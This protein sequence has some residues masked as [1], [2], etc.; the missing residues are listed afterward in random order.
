MLD[1]LDNVPN[2]R[3]NVDRTLES[4][5]FVPGTPRSTP[6]ADDAGEASLRERAFQSVL[7]SI[8]EAADP[9]GGTGQRESLLQNACVIGFGT[10]MRGVDSKQNDLQL[11]ELSKD[12]TDVSGK[13]ADGWRRLN[14]AELKQAGIDPA[15]LE[16][17]QT[18]FRAAIYT[19]GKG[20]YVLAYAGSND[21]KDW[22][23]NNLPQGLGQDPAQFKQ[24]AEL[25]R[26][27]DRAFG[28]QLVIT[29]HSLGGG[30]AATGALATGRTAVTF[31][32]EG[33][34]DN[35][36]RDIGKD[37]SQARQQAENGQIRAYSVDG[38][39]LTGAQEHTPIIAA[40]AP[41]H[42][43]KLKD[44]NPVQGP[45]TPWYQWVTDPGRAIG[46]EVND[47]IKDAQHAKELHGIDAMISAMRKGQPWS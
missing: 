22:R 8:V 39:P 11:A 9:T 17:P 28:D 15:K 27:A 20:R 41:G 42:H 3:P 19:D 5:R 21:I 23:D 7:A 43:I 10:Q 40:E 37:P 2:I 16:T 47:G 36:M 34:N 29:G 38:D 45:D 25:A 4:T 26:L 44:P 1:R 30:L 18:G 46:E 13:G 33:V 12:V 6:N 24:A 14:A 32:A 35:I 31:N